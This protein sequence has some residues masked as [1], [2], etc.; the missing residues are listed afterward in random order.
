VRSE[1]RESSVY[2]Q[3]LA[4][5]PYHT[6][7]AEA[8][9]G[10]YNIKIISLT[11]SLTRVLGIVVLVVVDDRTLAHPDC[12]RAHAP[13]HTP[14]RTNTTVTQKS[15]RVTSRGD[16]ERECVCGRGGRDMAHL[17]HLAFPSVPRKQSLMIS[18]AAPRS[19][20]IRIGA[21]SLHHQRKSRQG[22][23]VHP[24][25]AMLLGRAKSKLISDNAVE[26]AT[27]GS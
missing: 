26:M 9:S 2:Q 17:L 4:T 27:L 22:H 16:T 24:S 5:G 19:L 12:L 21:I 18:A 15:S 10:H 23:Q 3:D 13:A 14:I 6:K 1:Q 7:H 25:H 11:H 20:Q 8:T